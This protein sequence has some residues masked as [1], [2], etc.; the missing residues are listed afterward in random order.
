MTALTTTFAFHGT[1]ATAPR[2]GSTGSVTKLARNMVLFLASPFIGLAY[3]VLLPF[4]GIGML[5]WI[6]TEGLRKPAARVAASV[7]A[8]A[9]AC[10][11]PVAVAQRA[12]AAAEE[13]QAHGIGGA[14]LVAAKL[15]AAPFAGLAFVIVAPFAALGALAWIAI[16]T[17]CIRTA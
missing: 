15:L 11:A 8:P 13:P 3:A 5:L 1:V 2:V 4:V 7:E 17:A 12:E 10:E 16:R 9:V 6:A 14:V